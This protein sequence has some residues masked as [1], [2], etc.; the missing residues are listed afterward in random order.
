M[1]H[2]GAEDGEVPEGKAELV[3]GTKTKKNLTLDG[4]A[5]RLFGWRRPTM[6]QN[7]QPGISVTCL[8]YAWCSGWGGASPAGQSACH[9]QAARTL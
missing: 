2:A 6:I 4:L 9:T 5:S 1:N 3:S 8:L 7:R